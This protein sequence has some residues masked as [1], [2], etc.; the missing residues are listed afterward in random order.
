VSL[1]GY[2]WREVEFSLP[3]VLLALAA[4]P[5]L[6]LWLGKRSRAAAVPFPS[7][8]PLKS[9][10]VPLRRHRGRWR[11]LFMLLPLALL[12]VAIAR[13]RVPKGEIPDPRRGIDIML[14]LD[15]SSSMREKDYH[16][17]GKRV[18]RKEALIHV[19]RNFIQKREFDRL[20]IVAFARGPWLV[21][22]LTLDHEWALAAFKET[23]SSRGTAIGEGVMTAT[24]FLKKSSDRT[25]IIIVVTDGENSAG[26]QPY[27]VISYVK[28]EQVRVYSI[29]IGPQ[30]L[31][32]SQLLNHDMFELS[33]ATGGQLFQA[34]DTHSLESVYQMIDL[35]EKKEFVQKRHQTYRELFPYLAAAA[36]ALLLVQLIL[37]DLL[38][39]R[40]P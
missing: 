3:W 12:I 2:N 22:P 39:R 40:V 1:G 37:Q 7:I 36:L 28:K 6:A 18:S 32:G 38:R 17:E 21:S 15:F 23:Q 25:K 26:R 19:V 10:G 4:L 9:L 5:L 31:F 27:E 34:S 24:W 11:W 20:G 30:K 16:L 14:A 13:P 8:Q 33:K 35:L 29:L